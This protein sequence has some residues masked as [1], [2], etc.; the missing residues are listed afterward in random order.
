[1]HEFFLVSIAEKSFDG[2]KRERRRKSY[3]ADE[4]DRFYIYFTGGVNWH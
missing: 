4:E 1:M 2:K 3:S